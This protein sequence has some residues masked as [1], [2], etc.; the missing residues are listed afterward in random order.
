MLTYGFENF[1]EPLQCSCMTAII[2]VIQPHLQNRLSVTEISAKQ[3]YDKYFIVAI[4]TIINVQERYPEEFGDFILPVLQCANLI[5]FQYGT[6]L[7]PKLVAQCLH[8]L[9]NII[10]CDAYDVFQ[11]NNRGVPVTDKTMRFNEIRNSFFTEGQIQSMC[12]QSITNFLK[13]SHIE[14]RNWQESPEEFAYEETRH[15]SLYSIKASAEHFILNLTATFSDI[16]CPYIVSL[17][18]ECASR[19]RSTLDTVL[20]IDSI[21]SITVIC[22]YDLFDFIDIDTWFGSLVAELKQEG[23]FSSILRRRI[24]EVI[25]RWVTIKLAQDKHPQV[26]YVFVII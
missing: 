23:P 1:T 7:E 4:K 9:S 26:V 19:E 24:L 10:L 6:E 17:I 3:V 21:Y 11:R 2:E 20:L 16:V 13:L 8:L 22:S 5:S 12:V 14:L 15:V 18:K 25:G